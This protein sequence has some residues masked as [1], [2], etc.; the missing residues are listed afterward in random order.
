MIGL[1]EVGQYEHFARYDHYVCAV[2]IQGLTQQPHRLI[3]QL[4][5]QKKVG[6][7]NDAQHR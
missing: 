3:F 4:V 2:Y 5:K 6:N 1:A 7:E